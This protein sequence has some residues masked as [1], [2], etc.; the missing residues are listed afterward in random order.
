M[1]AFDS[2]LGPASESRKHNKGAIPAVVELADI[3]K[4][5]ERI[6]DRIHRTPLMSATELGRLMA[7]RLYIK[8][9]LFQKTGSFKVRGVL[10]KLLT[11]DPEVRQRGVLS[12]SAG[13]HAQ[14]L[15]WGA[16]VCR[17][18]ATVVM[19]QGAVPAKVRAT[20]AY[21]GEVIQTEG[22]LLETC[23]AIQ[24]ERG[25]PLVHPFDDPEV[26]AGHGTIGLEILEDLPDVEMVLVPAGGGGLLAGVAAAIKAQRPD[27]KVVG[28]EPLG[29]CVVYQSLKA[30]RPL[31]L[32][33]PSE[34]I[35]DGLAAPFC[36]ELTFAQIQRDV[37]EIVLVR[38]R[39]ILN[40]MWVIMERA[41]MVPEPAGAVAYAA[42]L[43]GAVQP[44]LNSLLACV[45]SGGN[46]S[47]QILERVLEVGKRDPFPM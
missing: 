17:T 20:K 27:I 8:C 2:F 26:I 46:V 10:N 22:D 25:L 37:D 30:G 13:N 45:I 15:A 1:Q 24:K 4:A 44:P 33:E 40:A 7:Q 38:E 18:R 41:K 21:M 31:R 19:P 43:S 28:V 29:S 16:I 39:D 23:L 47:P 14:A 6:A 42:V 3:L 36:G 12:F 11:M 5:R 9:E 34:T 35:A 32:E